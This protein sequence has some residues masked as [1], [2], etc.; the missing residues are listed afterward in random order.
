MAIADIRGY[1]TLRSRTQQC[2]QTGNVA[3]AEIEPLR[4]DRRKGVGG[5][6]DQHRAPLAE[7]V[8]DHARQ[9]KCLWRGI[10]GD[11]AEHRLHAL[12]DG[13]RQGFQRQRCGFGCSLGFAHPD[14]ARAVAGQGNLGERTILGVKFRRNIAVRQLMSKIED[15]GGLRIGPAMHIDARR[16]AHGGTSSIGTDNEARRQRTSVIQNNHACSVIDGQIRK[17]FLDPDD[18]R[19]GK[20]GSLDQRQERCIRDVETEGIKADLGGMEGYCRRTQQPAGAID[21]SHRGEGRRQRCDGGPEAQPFD[22]RDRLV[23]QGRRA[24]IAAL[25]CRSDE[26]HAI[27]FIRKCKRA[28]PAGKARA[29]D[30]NIVMVHDNLP[31]Q[32]LGVHSLRP[33]LCRRQP[34]QR[35]RDRLCLALQA[36]ERNGLN[37]RMPIAASTSDCRR[38]AVRHGFCWQL[39]AKGA[40]YAQHRASR[41][42]G[43]SEHARAG[44]RL[45]CWRQC[46]RSGSASLGTGSVCR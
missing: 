26:R 28:K 31:F 32:C 7:A 39:S 43:K 1:G 44:S 3:Q 45:S 25:G 29:D 10:D 27:T 19:M 33:C 35:H 11:P 14:E 41:K 22:E 12:L 2:N 17:G 6:T 4:A 37:Q 9:R 36:S 42:R 21:D 38:I 16:L 5:F 30:S 15:D 8:C 34:C 23:H 40:Y 24:A 46:A 18:P 20:H 13:E